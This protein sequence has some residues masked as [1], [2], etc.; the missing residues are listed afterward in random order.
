M[1]DL[2]RGCSRQQ[3]VQIGAS[4]QTISQ[5]IAENSNELKQVGH[6]MI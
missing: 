4:F 5:F 2:T 6:I 3:N 1:K